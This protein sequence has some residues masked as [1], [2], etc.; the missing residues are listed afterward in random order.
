MKLSGS[1][2]IF[3]TR[4]VG[5]NLSQLVLGWITPELDQAPRGVG[6]AVYITRQRTSEELSSLRWNIPPDMKSVGTR[7][8]KE[9]A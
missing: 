3:T 5:V 4:V 8:T 6:L 1:M 2:P 7:S 9:I